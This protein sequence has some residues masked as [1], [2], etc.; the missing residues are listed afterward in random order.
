MEDRRSGPG[1]DQDADEPCDRR[2]PSGLGRLLTEKWSRKNDHED[3]RQKRDRRALGQRQ[4]AQAAEKADRR[5]QKKQRTHELQ[6]GMS[7][8]PESGSGA[9]PS[10]WRHHQHL[11]GVASPDDEKQ[12]VV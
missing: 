10:E 2:D 5:S 11:A 3:R 6:H 4:I 12:G 8:A 9:L 1:K 7:R